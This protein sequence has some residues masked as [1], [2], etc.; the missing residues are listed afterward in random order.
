MVPRS[1]TPCRTN[2]PRS[3]AWST[4]R[5]ALYVLLATG[6]WAAAEAAPV[7]AFSL[8]TMEPAGQLCCS[9]SANLHVGAFTTF[10]C[11]P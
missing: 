3:W 9:Q 7:R 5:Q 6:M 1:S 10:I 4:S 8:K 11:V 2:L